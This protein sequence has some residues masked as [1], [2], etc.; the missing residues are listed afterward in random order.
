MIDS[1]EEKQDRTRDRV[2]GASGNSASD[3]SAPAGHPLDPLLEQLA[4]VRESAVQYLESQK[5]LTAATIRRMI[6]K[7]IIGTV[8]AVVG[9]TML[10]AVTVMLLSGLSA[11]VSIAAGGQP[12][13]GNLVV[14]GGLLVATA[15]GMGLYISKWMRSA[16]ERTIRKYESRHDAQ[17]QANGTGVDQRTAASERAV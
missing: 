3:S 15:I 4:A 6:A 14:G 17:R 16:R 11:G 7:A 1:T 5:D 8:A 10:V 9:V 12:W 13:V 2:F